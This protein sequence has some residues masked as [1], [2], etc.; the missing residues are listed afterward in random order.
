M[1]AT[2][3]RCDLWVSGYRTV[4]IRNGLKFPT[5]RDWPERAR[6]NPPAIIRESYD[7]D[8]AGTGIL[9]DGL[10]VIDIDIDDE[11][12]SDEIAFWC[13]DNFGEAPIR[14]RDN[15]PRKL[16]V[17]RALEGSPKKITC[18]NA[19]DKRGIEILGH[20]NQFF[21]YG[22]HPSGVKLDWMPRGP[23]QW[24]VKNLVKLH[25]DH[26]LDLF[27]TFRADIGETARIILATEQPKFEATSDPEVRI[28]DV[29]CTLA[30]IPNVHCGYEF[31]FSIAQ[32][33]YRCTG[34]SGEGYELW[35][36]W[37]SQSH[38]HRDKDTQKVWQALAKNPPILVGFGTL[39][40]WAKR[41]D[42]DFTLDLPP[43][44]LLERRLDW[45]KSRGL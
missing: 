34:G 5:D 35:R 16:L 7:P 37:S 3:M 11:A 4:A 36:S 19:V 22:V 2:K 6:R 12:L 18:W 21:A 27:D 10:R 24:P 41:N 29:Q 14:L 15:S 25:E 32:A 1:T 40:H 31:W 8:H 9:C 28:E 43:A 23:H 30:A 33:V 44:Y 26:F 39:T 42:A 17:Y 13:L 20:G 38:V 45:K